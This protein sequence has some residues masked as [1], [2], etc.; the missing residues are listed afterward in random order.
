MITKSK[1][2]VGT[3]LTATF[4]HVLLHRL[5]FADRLNIK[6]LLLCV[7]DAV[8]D[9]SARILKKKLTHTSREQPH[10]HFSPVFSRGPNT[11]W[12]GLQELGGSYSVRI[13]FAARF[14]TLR[15]TRHSV[16]WD[17]DSTNISRRPVIPSVLDARV[18]RF[19]NNGGNPFSNPRF[20]FLVPVTLARI[21]LA[22]SVLYHAIHL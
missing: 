14:L 20:T 13:V 6:G 11:R 18:L 8:N 10:F 4:S 15:A 5:A 9:S 22:C 19:D 1:L 2:G 16:G 7:P 21:L 12:Q 17:A 3:C